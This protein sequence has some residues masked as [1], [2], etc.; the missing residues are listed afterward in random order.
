MSDEIV[1]DTNNIDKSVGG[2]VFERF[3]TGRNEA[4]YVA[5]G[6]L[7]MTANYVNLIAFETSEGLFLVDTGMEEAGE[8]VYKEIRKQTDEIGRASCRERV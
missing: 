6:T 3:F 1:N 7:F 4:G 5:P 2:S 8:A